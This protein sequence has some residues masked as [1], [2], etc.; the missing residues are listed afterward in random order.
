MTLVTFPEGCPQALDWW[1]PL[2]AEFLLTELLYLA[3]LSLII[4]HTLSPV[5]ISACFTHSLL[6]WRLFCFTAVSFPQCFSSGLITTPTCHPPLP[7]HP[8]IHLLQEHPT[9]CTSKALFYSPKA[10]WTFACCHF[11]FFLVA[12][13]LTPGCRQPH[14]S[15]DS[16]QSLFICSS[17][18][19]SCSSKLSKGVCCDV[20]LLC[21]LLFSAVSKVSIALY[22]P[23]FRLRIMVFQP[24]LIYCTPPRLQLCSVYVLKGNPPAPL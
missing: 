1:F 10:S 21:S 17:K 2:A 6:I 11:F 4:I 22:L 5:S 19:E 13:Q 16:V 14:V 23:P 15:G 24:N 8:F 7:N 20:H 9:S 12:R 3:L 18:A